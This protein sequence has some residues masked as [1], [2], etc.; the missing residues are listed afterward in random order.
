[1]EITE[2][3]NYLKKHSSNQFTAK[4]TFNSC[5]ES[6]KFRL[7]LINHFLTTMESYKTDYIYIPGVAQD[8]FDNVFADHLDDPAVQRIEA[9]YD[10]GYFEDSTGAKCK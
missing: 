4:H 1:M 5:D 7:C 10:E 6:E 9:L 3:Y 8:Y 2:Y